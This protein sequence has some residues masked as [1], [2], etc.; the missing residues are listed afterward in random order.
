MGSIRPSSPQKKNNPIPEGKNQNENIII[1]KDSL[2]DYTSVSKSNDSVEAK[3]VENEIV[4]DSNSTIT[5][6]NKTDEINIQFSKEGENQVDEVLPEE[7][8]SQGGYL[9]LNYKSVDYNS[10]QLN[11]V[12]SSDATKVASSDATKVASSDA[13]KVASSD[14][15]KVASSRIKF[16]SDM[17]PKVISKSSLRS[18]SSLKPK[19]QPK[20]LIERKNELIE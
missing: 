18:R 8:N 4:L 3:P 7:N 16:D 13:T 2:I 12:A 20:K 5:I 17:I 1:D 10:P 9:V 14:A 15:T 19:K 6:T 11:K